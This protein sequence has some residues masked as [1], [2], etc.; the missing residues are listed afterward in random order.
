[1]DSKWPKVDSKSEKWIAKR[2]MKDESW[3]KREGS[4]LHSGMKDKRQSKRERKVVHKGFSS[5]LEA[6][7]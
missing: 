7:T 5:I 6:I 3:S 2:A 1:V 4:V